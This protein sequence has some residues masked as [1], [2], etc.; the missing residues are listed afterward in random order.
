MKYKIKQILN[1]HKVV[2]DQHGEL[3][4]NGSE[5][6]LHRMYRMFNKK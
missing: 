5:V 6:L 4:N 3:T 1:N 2:A